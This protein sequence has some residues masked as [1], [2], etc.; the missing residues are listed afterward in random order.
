MVNIVIRPYN[1]SSR[2]EELVCL[3]FQ[4]SFDSG[5]ATELSGLEV[6]DLTLE[7]DSAVLITGHHRLVGKKAKLPKP[8]A[9]IHKR[10]KEA[11]SMEE[12]T[13]YEVVTILKEK[14]LFA[15][16]PGLIVQESLRGLTKTGK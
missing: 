11:D 10:Q 2:K 16:R 1:S 15:S 12:G 7:G 13:S 3:E 8:L 4:G 9:V 5:D 14:Y 6:G